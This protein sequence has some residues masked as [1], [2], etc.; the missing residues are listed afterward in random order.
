MTDCV[1]F[2][3]VP[4]ANGRQIAILTLNAEKSHNALTLDMIR[5]IAPKFEAW[6]S[7]DSIAA[8]V[9]RGAGEK[10]FCAGG[11]VV[12]LMHAIKAGNVAV[13]DTFFSEEYD[14]DHAIHTYPKPI[15][16]WGH[17]IVMGGGLGLMAGASHR[18]VTERSRIAMPEIS[19]GLFPDVGGSWFLNRLP[20]KLGIYL[21]LTGAS[22][23]SA[24][25]RFIGLGDVALPSTCYAAMLAE[26]AD[27][28]W[29]LDG[30]DHQRLS[31]ALRELARVNP[32]TL[33]DSPVR[34]H[35]DAIQALTEEDDLAE[36][37][38]VIAS[39]D[40]EDEW[41]KSG[42]KKL[43]HGCPVSMHLIVESQRRARHM[44]LK[45]IFEMEYALA[46]QCCRHADFAEGV[47]ALLVDKDHS[48]NWVYKS[49]ADVPAEYIEAHFVAP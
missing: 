38:S 32:V 9:L 15:V 44:S 22:L 46:R 29:K 25:A 10:S 40:G 30:K 41:L 45:E 2:E 8:I 24:D 6:R 33:P 14:L 27:V 21:G 34:A 48:P 11:D 39:Y 37:V 28:E 36:M 20:G 4:T 42:A 23:N 19:I 31:G 18:I 5:A 1:L 47:R 49:V 43:A 16:V 3:F 17:G 26:M 13:C 7:D 12:S 35:Y